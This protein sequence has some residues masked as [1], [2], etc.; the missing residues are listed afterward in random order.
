MPV[1]RIWGMSD[2][3]PFADNQRGRVIRPEPSR[4]ARIVRG[5]SE[6]LSARTYERPSGYQRTGALEALFMILQSVRDN[7]HH[8]VPITDPSDAKGSPWIFS[9]R[10]ESPGSR[11]D[12]PQFFQI[13]V[14]HST[15]HGLQCRW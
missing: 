11:I 6:T 10:R 13:H 5:R 4:A 14:F 15:W 7:Q 12:D 3:R 2:L 1:P 8:S 9:S